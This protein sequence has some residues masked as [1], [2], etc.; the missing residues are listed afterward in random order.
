M[1]GAA[2]LGRFA[3]RFSSH[4]FLFGVIRNVEVCRN[5]VKVLV[6][7]YGASAATTIIRSS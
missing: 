6:L 2:S 5:Y 7:D 4:V 3:V 1:L